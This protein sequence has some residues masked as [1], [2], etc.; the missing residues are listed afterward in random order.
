MNRAARALRLFLEVFTMALVV[1]LAIVVVAAVVA[2]YA[3]N[4]SFIW[5]DEVAS[6]MLAW[7]TFYGA[8]LAAI[9]RRHLGFPG[10][11]LALPV[12]ARIAAF[13]LAEATV[14]AVFVALAYAGWL[15]LGILGSETLVSLDIPLWVTQSAVP[16]GAML[17]I[18]A[19]LLSTPQAWRDLL[20]GRSAED[21]EIEEELARAQA[22]FDPETLPVG[23]GESH[24][25][26]RRAS[27]R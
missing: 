12:P 19:Q 21:D 23:A 25:P 22:G 4:A 8:S 9:R 7:V 10:L 14:Y 1:G 11:V 27:V 16:V 17:F 6:V 5:Y 15:I 18:L 2:R 24:A 26:P 20:A 13:V 3:F